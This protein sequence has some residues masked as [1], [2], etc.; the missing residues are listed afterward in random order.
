[1]HIF[2]VLESKELS[3][4]KPKTPLSRSL[5]NPGQSDCSRVVAYYQYSKPSNLVKTFLRGG[6]AGTCIPETL[7]DNPRSQTISGPPSRNYITLLKI[8]KLEHCLKIK[9]KNGYS[10]F[11]NCNRQ[12]L[13]Q[14]NL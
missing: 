6:P 13:L 14:W 8:K 11:P 7:G 3:S 5:G 10:I 4:L 12:C 9:G 2:E 1:V